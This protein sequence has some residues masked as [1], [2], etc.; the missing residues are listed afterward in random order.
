MTHVPYKGKPQALP[1]IVGGQ[2]HLI[3]GNASGMGPHVKGGRVRGL[4]ITSIQRSLSYPELP[5]V[6]ESGV[7]EYEV[8]GW[9]GI[10]APTGVPK[11]ILHRLNIEVN[12]ALATPTVKEQYVAAG[13]VPTGSTPEEFGAFVRREVVKWAEVIKSAGITAD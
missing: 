13:N 2:V 11:A 3:F 5:I 7:P 10:I 12:K 4:A 8:V 9:G 1:D 6:A